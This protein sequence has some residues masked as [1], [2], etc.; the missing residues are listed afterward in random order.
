[1]KAFFSASVQL[2]VFFIP[3]ADVCSVANGAA[4]APTCTSTGAA[5]TLAEAEGDLVIV[6]TMAE[7]CFAWSSGHPG[8]S[9]CARHAAEML[10]IV[11]SAKYA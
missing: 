1:M 2:P 9:P 5:R 10:W 7:T 3:E 6:F 11:G 8:S 4:D